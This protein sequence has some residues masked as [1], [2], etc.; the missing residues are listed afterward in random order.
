M[1][2]FLLSEMNR[3][4]EDIEAIIIKRRRLHSLGYQ[5]DDPAPWIEDED[6]EAQDDEY[7]DL[8]A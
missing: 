3:H 4:Y 6:I 8:E 2:S 1:D 5:C 7:F